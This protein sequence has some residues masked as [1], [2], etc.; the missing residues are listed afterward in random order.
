MENKLNANRY[1]IAPPEDGTL[2]A[3]EGIQLF[4]QDTD[5]IFYNCELFNSASSN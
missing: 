3:R 4:L 2:S 5:L 1:Y